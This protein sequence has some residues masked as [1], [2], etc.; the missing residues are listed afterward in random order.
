[1]KKLYS[2][3]ILSVLIFSSCAK[4][5]PESK[6]V[7]NWKLDDVVKRRFLNND[8]LTTGYEAGVFTFSEN[9]TITY[10]DTITLSGNWRMH[11]EDRSYYDSDGNYQQRN[12]LVLTMRLANFAANR[13]IDW[14]FDDIDFKRSSN[15]LDGFM[16]YATSSYQYSFRRQ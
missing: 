13:F 8:H 15:R 14:D 5:D 12:N 10:T 1:M 3:A 11:Y 2:L 16:Y 9:G 6:I 7:G 4:L